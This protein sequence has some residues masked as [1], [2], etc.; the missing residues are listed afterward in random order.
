[1]WWFRLL[2][3]WLVELRYG[4]MGLCHCLIIKLFP[5]AGRAWKITHYT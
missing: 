1:M 2:A 3:K 4:V 5:Q